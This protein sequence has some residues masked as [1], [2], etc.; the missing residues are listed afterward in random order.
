MSKER[1]SMREA[2][3]RMDDVTRDACSET[4]KATIGKASTAIGEVNSL[5]RLIEVQVSTAK[6]AGRVANIPDLDFIDFS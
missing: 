5:I 2:V 1:V 4:G 6:A 3:K